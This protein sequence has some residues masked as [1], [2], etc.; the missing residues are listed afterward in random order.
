MNSDNSLPLAEI[1]R[2]QI[3]DPPA[4]TGNVIAALPSI[5]RGAVWKVKQI[6]ELW[7]SIL[8][9][10][11]IGA[12][13]ISPID[14][15]KYGTQPFKHQ[16]DGV[17]LPEPTHHLLDGQQRATGI[18]L[19][20]FDIWRSEL[21]SS[22]PKSALWIDLGEPPPNRDSDFLFRLVT[23]AHPWG[24]SRTD[25][26]SRLSQPQIRSALGAFQT[27]NSDQYSNRRPEDF[28]LTL[29]WPWDADAPVPLPLLVSAVHKHNGDVSK[30][31]TTV[32]DRI[33][34]L[35]F[36]AYEPREGLDEEKSI[37]P[38][39]KQRDNVL[40]AFQNQN[41]HY[42]HRLS[43]VLQR[44]AKIVD[45]ESTYRVPLLLL[46][47]EFD[48][49]P[50]PS[51]PTA[52]DIAAQE[53]PASQT[54]KK[55]PVELLFVRIN[56]AGTPLAGEEL[57]YSLLKS[58]WVEAPQF[59]DKLDHK[60]ALPSRLAM[61]C[62]RL[63]LARC[64]LER[65]P[66]GTE[67]VN[68]PLPPTPSIAEFRRLVRNS[69]PAHPRFFETL[70][71]FIQSDAGKRFGGA[72][73]FL[74]DEKKDY[75]L[76]PVLAVE[77]AQKA[78]DVFLLLL[79]WIDRLEDGSIDIANFDEKAHRRTLGFLTSLAWF[80][81]D[82]TKAA[83]VVWHALQQEGNVEN[84]K[85]FFNKKRFSDACRLD[86][87]YNLRMIPL[88][89]PDEFEKFC[90]KTITGHQGCQGTITSADSKIWKDDGNWYYSRIEKMA[91]NMKDSYANKLR[92]K[93]S[94]N[95][96]DFDL[97]GSTRSACQTF[98]DTL[99]DGRFIL[100]YAQRDWLRKWFPGFKPSL[101]EY[102]ED[103]NRPWDYDHIHPQ[104]YLRSDNG[105]SLRNIPQLIR[106]WHGSI[107]NLRA[108]PL[109][110]NRADSDISPAMKLKEINEVE[111]RYS[112]TCQQHKHKAS[113]VKKE[114][115]EWWQK[116]V[117]DDEKRDY[118]KSKEYHVARQALIMAIITRF[119]ALYREWYESLKLSDLQ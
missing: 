98:F 89:T 87:R 72:W 27:V 13:V 28:P 97:Y 46:H 67:K 70:Q 90:K 20:F 61:F 84:L 11:P 51:K 74:T 14:K 109:E 77:L 37:A 19:G 23:R 93:N 22:N 78:P 65:R 21:D 56:S 50:S 43:F 110:A 29:T 113:F 12:F 79:R 107:G 48:D 32:W 47:H 49:A 117:P 24:Y 63:V 62:I 95:E 55:D 80:A 44:L 116:S 16:Q 88:P 102:M 38:L 59:I 66:Q 41:S 8:R 2:W 1:A 118:L 68:V 26:D 115:W 111:K 60:P 42:A 30:A 45:Q 108:W 57:I 6:E 5:Q 52:D 104:R 73:T 58:A 81:P 101:P 114:D 76:P 53:T 3:A 106:D 10:F 36:I 86:E 31:T 35:P 92:S 17:M 25:P 4:R 9:R 15:I 83:A 91:E 99:W 71:G 112:M 33:K 34:K 7:D 40:K 94:A 82:K 75:T 103:K 64:Q 54:E 85:D 105:N 39:S 96:D 69:N 18:A 100:L 119:N